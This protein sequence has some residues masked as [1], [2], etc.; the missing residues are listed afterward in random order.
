[1]KRMRKGRVWLLGASGFIGTRLMDGLA[2][3]SW[4]LEGPGPEELDLL[5][6]RQVEAA[7]GSL[8]GE[9]SVIM[10][11]A[12]TRLSANTSVSMM[13]NIQMARHVADSLE[14]HPTGHVIY[15]ST[16]DVYGAAEG[17]GPVDER[18]APRPS[19]PYAISKLAGEHLLR[20]AAE[21][22]GIPFTLF[23]LP[24]VYGRGGD[25]KSMINQLVAAALATRTLTVHGDGRALRDYVFV[26]DLGALVAAALDRRSDG[27][28]N[29]G[30]GRPHPVRSI[31]RF[32]A[33]QMPF[34]VEIRREPAPAEGA[35]RPGDLRVAC[36]ALKA[37]FR[38][39]P[40]RDMREGIGA[41]LA[42]LGVR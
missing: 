21:K 17:G 1:M 32:V 34:P 15:L 13:K 22:G 18:T 16:Q 26:D 25:G 14:R 31:V 11:A 35:G 28:F 9:D 41:Y 23:R 19:D 2:S 42:Q 24:G 33:E 30:T 6:P 40:V 8:T 7:L 12:I 38:D 5:K 3:A 20:R 36:S 39:V 10:A 37:C 4:T 27:L 29:V